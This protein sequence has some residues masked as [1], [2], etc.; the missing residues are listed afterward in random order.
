V[1]SVKTQLAYLAG[2]WTTLIEKQGSGGHI[3][4]GLPVTLDETTKTKALKAAQVKRN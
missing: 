3:F 4:K 1:I 2:L